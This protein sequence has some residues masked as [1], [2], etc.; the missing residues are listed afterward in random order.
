MSPEQ[1]IRFA[2]LGG[3]KSSE[4]IRKSQQNV[5]LKY[6]MSEDGGISFLDGQHSSQV[7]DA[8]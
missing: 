3:L 2:N 7:R 8:S 6:Y 1:K 4:R 5:Q